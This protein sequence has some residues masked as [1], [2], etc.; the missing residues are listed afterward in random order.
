MRGLARCGYREPTQVQAQV[1][2]LAMDGVDLMVSAATG[3]GKTAAFLLPTMQRFMDVR[4]AQG[5]TRAL[6]LV[7]TRELARQIHDHFMQLGSYTRLTAEVITGGEPRAHQVAKLRRN[8]EILIATPGRLLELLDSHHAELGDLEILVL[9]EADRMLD[10]GFADDVLAIIQHSPPERQSLLFSATLHH[11]GLAKI[12]DSLLRAPEVLVIDPVREQHPDISHQMVLSDDPAHKRQQ[13]LW[14]LQNETFEKTLVF[15][16]T[17]DGA[18]GVGAFLQA[19]KQRAAVLHGLLD[20]RERNRIIGLLQS[21]G[22]HVLV[23]TDVAA[24]GLDIP[25]MDYVV[26]FDL[27]RSGDDYLHRTGRT[28]RAGAKGRALSLVGPT[29]W[30]RMESIARYLN[31]EIEPFSITG[32]EAK[33][34]GPKRRKPTAKRAGSGRE[35]VRSAEQRDKPKKKHRLKD[36]KSIGKRRKP[37]ST[38]PVEAGHTP[39]RKKQTAREGAGAAKASGKKEPT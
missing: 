27:P 30:N 24:R 38:S 36:R 35:R 6:V 14:L 2:P 28:G 18:E 31:L 32:L 37:S 10:M 15:T 26:N 39:L 1:I 19:S 33:F 9:D 5:G 16:N 34:A 3:S 29:E 11:R 20:Q 23:A 7:P 17:R 25:G 21:G 22:I 13:L 4:K 12:T 8:P